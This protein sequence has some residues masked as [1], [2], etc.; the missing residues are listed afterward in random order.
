MARRYEGDV[1]EIF[2]THFLSFVPKFKENMSIA[3]TAK[4]VVD[5]LIT[6]NNICLRNFWYIRSTL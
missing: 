4:N 1:T 5:S 6:E 3:S 2:S